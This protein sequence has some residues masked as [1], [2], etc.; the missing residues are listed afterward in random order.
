VNTI[1]NSSCWAH[2]DSVERLTIQLDGKNL[3]YLKA[4]SGPPIPLVHGLLGYS[5]SWRFTIPMLAE[6]AT[7]YALDLPGAGSSEP[8]E[9]M[10]C[11]F[12]ACA[13][14]LLH[15][16]D[17][18]GIDNCDLLGT[19][20]GGAVAMMATALAPQRIRRLI[21][22]DPVNPW[23]AHGQ[24]LSILLSNFLIAPIFCALMPHLPLLQ[25][26]YFGRL[27]GDTRR[28]SP[29]ALEGYLGPLR[30][31]GALEYG[32][33]ILR[34]W[35]RDLRELESVL[36]RISEVPTLLI[37]GSLDAAVDPR[38]ASKLKSQFHNCQLVMLDGVGHIPYEET[39]EEFTRI[40][41]EFLV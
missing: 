31:A 4:G 22:V 23:S 5:F 33:G 26:F 24:L 12:R 3:F 40:V 38:S 8:T 32:V 28:I 13:E 36:P 21:L 10:D 16:M 7:V 1:I 35:N 30:R 25:R 6:I 9:G 14:R 15:F 39:P 2:A 19:S 34:S 37:W 27:F 41:R 18:V 17:A 11:S 20:H 29:G